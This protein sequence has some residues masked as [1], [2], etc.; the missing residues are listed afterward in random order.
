MQDVEDMGLER[1][2]ARLSADWK[3]AM[4]G[5]GACERSGG[6]YNATYYSCSDERG[7]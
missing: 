7:D 3:I 5:Q 4:L 2:R 1:A 6:P